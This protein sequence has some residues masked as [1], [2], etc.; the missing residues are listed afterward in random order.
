MMRIYLIG[1]LD[2]APDERKP[3]E[4]SLEENSGGI[5]RQEDDDDQLSSRSCCSSTWT[6]I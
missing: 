3:E 2:R 5:H 1:L 4:F 6:S